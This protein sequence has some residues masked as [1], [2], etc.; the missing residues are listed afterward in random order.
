MRSNTSRMLRMALDSVSWTMRAP[1]SCFCASGRERKV[2]PPS[3]NKSLSK[4]SPSV[5]ASPSPGGAWTMGSPRVRSGDAMVI[6]DRRRSCTS[7]F[8]EA[9]QAQAWAGADTVSGRGKGARRIWCSTH[10][11]PVMTVSSRCLPFTIALPRARAR[12]C[13]TPLALFLAA[14]PLDSCMART[15][16]TAC[17]LAPRAGLC[18]EAPVADGRRPGDGR[19]ESDPGLLVAGGERDCD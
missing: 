13:S 10:G 16:D 12:R 7:R 9:L 8:F 2:W 15:V 3:P 11:S 18:G 17:S 1:V 19:L 6:T 5:P 4:A 14:P